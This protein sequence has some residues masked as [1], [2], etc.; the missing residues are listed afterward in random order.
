MDNAQAAQVQELQVVVKA[1]FELANECMGVKGDPTAFSAVLEKLVTSL[2]ALEPGSVAFVPGGWMNN[3][4][5]V[6]PPLRASL[7]CERECVLTRP[8]IPRVLPFPALDQG[9]GVGRIS[10]G[11]VGGRR[12]LFGHDLQPGARV[13]V[14][15]VCPGARQDAVRAVPA[16]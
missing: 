2:R 10:G 12:E 5:V 11:A 3:M 15:P 1:A 8:R 13:R 7:G 6:V 16:P 4:Y 14:P 9:H